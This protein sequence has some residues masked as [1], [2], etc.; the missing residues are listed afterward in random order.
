MEERIRA[1]DERY[2]KWTVNTTATES[3]ATKGSPS[4][5]PNS[6]S[7]CAVSSSLTSVSV[8]TTCKL[9]VSKSPSITST[10]N[11][12]ISNSNS[13]VVAV[14]TSPMRSLCSPL[15]PPVTIADIIAATTPPIPSATPINSL[16]GFRPS[17][18]DVSNSNNAD[19]K[20]SPTLSSVSSSPQNSPGHR[21]KSTNSSPKGR[22][23]SISSSLLCKTVSSS[24]VKSF[25]SP[26]DS[27]DYT[28]ALPVSPMP[29]SPAASVPPAASVTQAA[30][31]S[32]DFMASPS[33]FGSLSSLS[34]TS[35]G[36]STPI[37]KSSGSPRRTKE[38]IIACTDLESKAEEVSSVDC[39]PGTISKTSSSSSVLNDK[40]DDSFVLEDSQQLPVKDWDL[41][42][43]VHQSETVPDSTD[44][45]QINETSPPCD[46]IS[47]SIVRTSP[48]SKSRDKATESKSRQPLIHKEVNKGQDRNPCASDDIKNLQ[49][50]N[51]DYGDEDTVSPCWGNQSVVDTAE[52]VSTKKRRLGS[53]EDTC[54]PDVENTSRNK[55][56]KNTRTHQYSKKMRMNS[57][58][59]KSESGRPDFAKGCEYNEH[60][61]DGVLNAEIKE[62]SVELPLEKKSSGTRVLTD[63]S[64]IVRK[65]NCESKKTDQ[66]RTPP[67]KEIPEHHDRYRE[68]KK[69]APKHREV[70]QED[71]DIK[72]KCESPTFVRKTDHEDTCRN[73]GQLAADD[74]VKHEVKRRNSDD[75]QSR[76]LKKERCKEK[77]E[78][79][80]SKNKHDNVPNAGEKDKIKAVKLSNCEN[81]SNKEERSGNKYSSSGHR[82]GDKRSRKSKHS[83]S[84]TT[85]VKSGRRERRESSSSS[86]SAVFQNDRP[87][88]S[89]AHA[90]ESQE[91]PTFTVV[92]SA[93]ARSS[94]SSRRRSVDGLD[95]K[96]LLLPGRK[97]HDSGRSDKTETESKGKRDLDSTK[98]PKYDM[99]KSSYHVRSKD[100]D[101]E[102]CNIA[103]P[104]RHSLSCDVMN[105]TSEDETFKNSHPYSSKQTQNI[106]NSASS[107]SKN[108]KR[109]QSKDCMASDS[110]SDDIVSSSSSSDDDDDHQKMASLFDDPVIDPCFDMY[111][112]VKSRHLK[113]EQKKREQERLKEEAKQKSILQH[114]QKQ[115]GKKKKSTSQATL[116]GV[117]ES[118]SDTYED[119]VNNKRVN[120]RVVASSTDDDRPS[121]AHVSS[122]ESDAGQL[123]PRSEIRKPQTSTRKR[124]TSSSSSNR[125]K[126][127]ITEVKSSRPVK[128]LVVSDI[129]S[130]EDVAAKSEDMSD[131]DIV[132]SKKH[133]SKNSPSN[134]KQEILSKKP[135]RPALSAGHLRTPC[136]ADRRKPNPIHSLTGDMF[137]SEDSDTPVIEEVKPCKPKSKAEA[138]EISVVS[139]TSRWDRPAKVKLANKERVRRDVRMEA[140]FGIMSDDSDASTASSSVTPNKSPRGVPHTPATFRKTSLSSTRSYPSP[141][142]L[143]MSPS[144]NP[145]LNHYTDSE[146]DMRTHGHGYTF[147]DK[148]CEED[149]PKII[150][151]IVNDSSKKS[152]H[153]ITVIS[154]T[155]DVLEDVR[156]TSDSGKGSSGVGSSSSSTSS[157]GSTADDLYSQTTAAKDEKENIV[158]SSGTDLFRYSDDDLII[159]SDHREHSRKD[160][161]KKKKHRDRDVVRSRHR[162]RDRNKHPATD[163]DVTIAGEIGMNL[164]MSSTVDHGSSG[165]S[166]LQVIQSTP[167]ISTYNQGKSP[168][169]TPTSSSPPFFKSKNRLSVSPAVSPSCVTKSP[170]SFTSSV[171]NKYFVSPENLSKGT[172]Q[173]SL[174]RDSR[175]SCE[176]TESEV[177]PALDMPIIKTDSDDEVLI[178][179]G[180]EMSIVST[181][182][183]K[184]SSP[185]RDEPSVVYETDLERSKDVPACESPRKSSNTT[186]ASRSVISQEETLNAVAG[187]LASYD[188]YAD[189]T[190]TSG[191]DEENLIASDANS[192]VEEDSQEAQTAAQML[193]SEMP[194]VE[195][196]PETRDANWPAGV[197]ASSSD[198]STT[199]TV[200]PVAREPSIGLHET[201]L[202]P[203][204]IVSSISLPLPSVDEAPAKKGSSIDSA[205]DCDVVVTH[206][207]GS[208]ITPEKAG[209]VDNITFPDSP[210]SVQSEPTLQI[211]EDPDETSEDIHSAVDLKSHG[212]VLTSVSRATEKT[213]VFRLDNN[214]QPTPPQTPWVEDTT[215]TALDACPRENTVIKDNKSNKKQE[216][217]AC[218]MKDVVTL[219]STYQSSLEQA[220]DKQTSSSSKQQSTPLVCS[221]SEPTRQNFA[222]PE[223]EAS[224]S[225]ILPYED[226]KV[227]QD[228]LLPSSTM[229]EGKFNHN[230]PY[231][232][233]ME[234]VKPMPCDPP[235]SKTEEVAS[236]EHTVDSKVDVS[237]NINE[238]QKEVT[239]SLL[240]KT[241]DNATPLT[242]S[243]S[244]SHG[245]HENNHDDKAVDIQVQSNKLEEK[246]VDSPASKSEQTDNNSFIQENVEEALNTEVSNRPLEATSTQDIAE[247][248]GS[249]ESALVP[250]VRGRGGRGRSRRGRGRVTAASND[251]TGVPQP[252]RNKS[253]SR[254]RPL[255][256]DLTIHDASKLNSLQE[257]RRSSRPKRVRRHPDMVD[258]DESSS[259]RRRGMRGVRGNL[260]PAAP[261]HDVFEFHESDDDTSLSVNKAK[262]DPLSTSAKSPIKDTTNDEDSRGSGINV[263]KSRRLLDKNADDEDSNTESETSSTGVVTPLTFTN[264]GLR[265][266]A[267]ESVQQRRNVRGGR[268]G[269]VGQHP[270]ALPKENPTLSLPETSSVVSLYSPNSTISET[271]SPITPISAGNSMPSLVEAELAPKNAIPVM[272][273]I[274]SSNLSSVSSYTTDTQTSVVTVPTAITSS[275]SSPILPFK[276]TQKESDPTPLVDPVTGHLTPMTM[277]KE[278]Q[279]IPVS[280]DVVSSSPSTT[281][282]TYIS[283]ARTPKTEQT[284]VTSTLPVASFN[285][286]VISSAQVSST[287]TQFNPATKAL[288]GVSAQIS[289]IVPSA[290]SQPSNLV[291]QSGQPSSSVILP[292]HAI[293]KTAAMMGNAH[294]LPT[295]P[296]IF[297]S[298]STAKLPPGAAQSA[299]ALVVNS[300]S[301]PGLVVTQTS[302]P[303]SIV[304]TQPQVTPPPIIV[305]QI[306]RPGLVVSH[307]TRPVGAI[308]TSHSALMTRPGLVVTQAPR[309]NLILRTADPA[310]SVAAVVASH[311][312]QF[313][314]SG[315]SLVRAPS[316]ILPNRPELVISPSV[317]Q[318][319]VPRNALSTASQATIF[320]LTSVSHNS[321]VVPCTSLKQPSQAYV[322]GALHRMG[323]SNPTPVNLNPSITVTSVASRQATQTPSGGVTAF[324]T[325]LP[326]GVC[327]GEVSVEVVRQPHQMHLQTNPGAPR[328]VEASALGGSGANVSMSKVSVGAVSPGMTTNVTAMRRTAYQ[329][330]VPLHLQAGSRPHP[331]SPQP[332]VTMNTVPHQPSPQ[333][334]HLHPSPQA[335]PHL[336]HQPSP[337]ASPQPVMLHQTGASQQPQQLLSI[338]GQLHQIVTTSVG[339]ASV[340]VHASS[341]QGL[342]VAPVTN[343]MV[344]GSRGEL[345]PTTRTVQS[346]NSGPQPQLLSTSQPPPAHIGKNRPAVENDP[347]LQ[348][349]DMS[350]AP[351]MYPGGYFV[352]D[353]HRPIYSRP[354]DGA[355]LDL[356]AEGVGVSENSHE[357][358]PV[359]SPALGAPSRVVLTPHSA[360]PRLLPHQL[361]RTTE[362]PKSMVFVGQ[363]Y[364]DI[365]PG[366][367]VPAGDSPRPAPMER[368]TST[369]IGGEL[370]RS[371]ASPYPPFAGGG[372]QRVAAPHFARPGG[373][374]HHDPTPVITYNHPLEKYPIFWEGVLGLKNDQA[375][376]QMLFV[377]GSTEVA[378]GALPN[379]SQ[380]T[381]ALR[382]SQRMRLEQLQLDG[383][384]R[385]M[386]QKGEHAVLVAL[387]FGH[388]EFDSHQQQRTLNN[389]FISYLGNK[390]AAGIVNVTAPG[391]QSPTFVIH[392]FPPCEFSKSTLECC[393]PDAF[394]AVAEV[395]HLLIVIATC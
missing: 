202:E 366:H 31:L 106:R 311:P 278:G 144:Q 63:M 296:A 354:G 254:S 289:Q 88:S 98:L 52:E 76:E 30:T 257:P 166:P 6:S 240:V 159:D 126:K 350:M 309:P 318:S 183:R 231:S 387:P 135:P 168:S 317:K 15:T 256:D 139:N 330:A 306:N 44:K 59:E 196:E 164:I 394:Q 315:V 376:V 267:K 363:Q 287:N 372:E 246:C 3:A 234:Q 77:T 281:P 8:T 270:T 140:I 73:I 321:K 186:K 370:L 206:S 222:M 217:P 230:E 378:S 71:S 280:G 75:V 307:T 53:A 27:P 37:R 179:N 242:D 382:I 91:P 20:V 259:R 395:S 340:L 114:K 282:L 81:V 47:N 109:L 342:N 313:I 245:T 26:T 355:A 260:R 324:R 390:Q 353:P 247:T 314:P 78:K 290:T 369:P 85:S 40:G 204:L 251:G 123:S 169:F 276:I 93:D 45:N 50:S 255:N 145:V 29:A 187:L 162:S 70:K 383:V 293:A 310:S 352:Q 19:I 107:K 42:S 285:P 170:G 232:D 1:F 248:G 357:Q 238:E 377:S 300:A 122:D 364:Y 69:D 72:E 192:V 185:R 339:P 291:R 84:S 34:P 160:K 22:R 156:P 341:H 218:Q 275:S 110:D 216:D 328:T 338:G 319:P 385:K 286:T 211:D 371:T 174:S 244:D 175:S 205:D 274:S 195:R 258:H 51:E 161:K 176:Q 171:S 43:N 375:K 215:I 178:T 367:A 389:G 191:H 194:E 136:D 209:H 119:I 46:T 384:A 67:D 129:S 58:S 220:T 241:E 316:G 243:F 269:L 261:T 89:P 146:D 99:K 116:S 189:N 105:E 94:V 365:Y 132:P 200:P 108:K 96:E 138:T 197:P 9:T 177:E 392:I 379:H 335:S 80:N 64:K 199:E 386:Q 152:L 380:E 90:P 57:T 151:E 393:A 295:K 225:S 17:L 28:C 82:G 190:R 368:L 253:R 18:L 143:P 127:S 141:G 279:Y 336:L 155:A 181:A 184:L 97:K 358:L 250:L 61:K 359:A 113:L 117:G 100:E 210:T 101:S 374:L 128:D 233:R 337:Q 294:Q 130:D 305:S 173:S 226:M 302:R 131:Y 303:Q 329:A 356:K 332:H 124:N 167:T 125:N 13:S 65:V 347:S 134:D 54:K 345:E 348:P 361:E 12:T 262:K 83:E 112:K 193:Q 227:H 7:I 360:S 223:L 266:K 74:A 263:R 5:T 154:T 165:K 172:C 236:P 121:L 148:P 102:E 153:R 320:Q 239:T 292:S 312:Q 288:T 308:M 92:P 41:R 322:T 133:H 24:S 79:G 4:S 208:K 163:I 16:P 344:S 56:I 158:E 203:P 49:N 284:T 381:T 39:S 104:L 334:A 33:S 333:P 273:V 201:T 301:R 35:T 362:S 264:A 213:S 331:L 111:D 228:T 297:I 115:R 325:A 349:F 298:T 343:V 272:R 147:S 351:L 11:T 87:L 326:H 60:V 182:F 157:T 283:H 235:C 219:E 2:E 137:H 391:S 149:A 68:L 327:R 277:V 304:V 249:A 207:S 32:I 38:D 373:G 323:V 150:E 142:D 48:P 214:E 237:P 252:T 224:H 10:T 86:L 120:P 23:D 62:E 188:E 118:D 265:F 388:N 212:A 36:N 95:S 221:P 14:R 271:L 66:M 268:G 299:A 198:S 21:N 25:Y 229:N 180:D 103:L 346:S 55:A